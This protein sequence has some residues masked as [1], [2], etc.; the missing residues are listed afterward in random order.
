M[1]LD[2]IL[3]NIRNSY[4]LNLLEESSASDVSEM[5]VLKGKK[6]INE[7]TMM[8][9]RIL[10]QEGVMEDVKAVIGAQFRSIIEESFWEDLSDKT[11]K[12][13]GGSTSGETAQLNGDIAQLNGAIDHLAKQAGGKF[14][15]MGIGA[16]ETLT[17]T[18]SQIND[19]IARGQKIP[20]ELQAK[21]ESAASGA[22][23]M[24]NN[25]PTA[26]SNAAADAKA[27]IMNTPAAISNAAQ[28]GYHN[29]ANYAQD[30]GNRIPNGNLTNTEAG[31]GA[32]AL[33]LG[34]GLGAAA[35]AR[36]VNQNGMR[37]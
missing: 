18:K 27:A 5:E 16:D 28:N 9:R 21:Y 34:A 3:E 32:G 20:A 36:R 10:I 25:A 15:Q 14:A 11:V 17:S 23:D 13:L 19:L 29:V 1:K 2:L 31:V 6:L 7:S 8:L 37:R 24:Y 4:T 22:K 12:L 33:G 30:L 35:I 26:I